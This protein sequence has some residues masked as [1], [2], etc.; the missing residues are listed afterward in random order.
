MSSSQTPGA[1][2]SIYV[3]ALIQWTLAQCERFSPLSA[4]GR[5]SP[6]KDTAAGARSTVLR[7][8]IPRAIEGDA[9]RAYHG[10][11]ILAERIQDNTPKIYEFRLLLPE[12][13][14]LARLSPEER[15][16]LIA[17]RLPTV[18]AQFPLRSNRLQ[19]CVKLSRFERR[20]IHGRPWEYQFH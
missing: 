13:E 11:V 19:A 2:L 3:V 6:P 7:R 8:H 20:P 10:F 17:M 15:K 5:A 14:A 1:S 18:P 9:Q 12:N 4:M 16:F